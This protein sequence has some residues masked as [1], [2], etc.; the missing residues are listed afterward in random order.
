MTKH[1]H[2]KA[3]AV[4][5]NCVFGRCVCLCLIIVLHQER[6]GFIQTLN[7]EEQG[8]CRTSMALFKVF[9]ELFKCQ[10]NKTILSL[11]YCKLI[12]EQDENAEE[13]MGHL[14]I[15]V[16]EFGYKEKDRRFKEQF[17]DGIGDNDMMTEIIRE[18]T[19]IKKTN[20]ITSKRV[21]A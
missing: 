10:H 17:I 7:N 13:W 4:H 14:I 11:Q 3:E 9:S 5:Q 6:F 20:E 8:K 16:N 2:T 18:L 12:K 1:K 21:E 19:A 15:K